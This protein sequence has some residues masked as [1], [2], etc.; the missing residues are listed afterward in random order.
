[1]REI[2]LCVFVCVHVCVCVWN[3]LASLSRSFFSSRLS[4]VVENDKSVLFFTGR[5]R[6]CASQWVWLSN[7]PA[8]IFH[9]LLDL[10]NEKM[11]DSCPDLK[12]MCQPSAGVHAWNAYGLRASWKLPSA[13]CMVFSEWCE[14]PLASVGDCCSTSFFPPSFQSTAGL[15]Q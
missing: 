9:L 2:R 3:S 1:M 7:L 10:L 8:I 14:K 11:S 15:N 6:L 5:D 4:I 13:P 12:K